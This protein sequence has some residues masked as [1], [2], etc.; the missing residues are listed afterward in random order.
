MN[1][2]RVLEK[3]DALEELFAQHGV[4]LAYIFGS[5][6][7][8][9]AGPLSDLDFAVLLG[10]GVEHQAWS[11]VQIAVMGELMSLFGRNDVDL[12]ILNRATPLLAQQVAQHG[13]VLYEEESGIRAEFEVNAL[14][15]YMDTKPLR[16]IQNRALLRRIEAYRHDMGG[17]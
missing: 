11:N 12:V 6:G 16:R 10:P 7:E 15:R 9:N 8:G 5:E 2:P 4:V 3:Q 14:R 17:T 1:T 13:R